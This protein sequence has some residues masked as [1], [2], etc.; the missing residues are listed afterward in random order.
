VGT[1][2]F[3]RL[4]Q[5]DTKFTYRFVVVQEIIGSVFY[6]DQTM[7]KSSDIL[8]SC[9]LEMLGS[10]TELALQS[11]QFAKSQLENTIE[12]VLKANSLQFRSGPFRSIICNDEVVWES[13]GIPMCSLSRFPYPEYHSDQ[14]NLAI[15]SPESLAEA[16]ELLYKTV[17]KLDKMTLMEKKFESVF[18]LAHPQYNL[19]VD[20]GQPA[21]GGHTSAEQAALRSLMDEIAL[22]PQYTFVDGIAER[23]ELP[24]DVVKGYLQLWENNGLIT[25]T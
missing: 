15:I 12:D 8:E 14:D 16:V 19:Y 24:L 3:H 17:Q 1:E 10:R 11:S 2:L 7:K 9:F 21:F 20:P 25:L 13:H 18:S 23:L 22:L 4:S 6:L 5:L